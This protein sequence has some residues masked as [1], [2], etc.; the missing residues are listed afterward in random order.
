MFGLIG[1]ILKPAV[2]LVGGVVSSIFGGGRNRAANVFPQPDPN[3]GGMRD[4]RMGD[5]FKVIG[6]MFK[7]MSTLAHATGAAMN[8]PMSGYS[9]RMS[10]FA[11]VQQE[12]LSQPQALIATMQSK[13]AV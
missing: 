13:T 3:I 1:A 4:P 10:A 11:R 9:P 6:A 5:F 2:S 8:Q 12:M 7:M